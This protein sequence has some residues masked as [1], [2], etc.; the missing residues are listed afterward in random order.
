MLRPIAPSAV[1]LTLRTHSQDRL[2]NFC[3]NVWLRRGHWVPDQVTAAGGICA[4]GKSGSKS[5]RVTWDMVKSCNPDVIV[6]AFCGFDLDEC[7]RRVEEIR[8]LPDWKLLTS[9]TRVYATDASAYFSRP[10]PRLVD[11]VELLAYILLGDKLSELRRPV[12]GQVSEY[13][14]GQWID[15]S[16]VTHVEKDAALFPEL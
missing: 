7:Q 2:T 13:V 11:G 4:L 5:E 14:Q 1:P 12:L 3:T 10:G 9:K 8:D 6:L 16:S 15:L